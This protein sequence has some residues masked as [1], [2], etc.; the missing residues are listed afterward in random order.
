MEIFMGRDPKGQ[1]LNVDETFDNNNSNNSLGLGGWSSL[2]CVVLD[3]TKDATDLLRHDLD[4]DVNPWMQAALVLSALPNNVSGLIRRKAAPCASSTA[5]LDTCF[6]F[7][8]AKTEHAVTNAEKE[9]L[10]TTVASASMRLTRRT[11]ALR[12]TVAVPGG[13]GGPDGPRGQR[14]GIIALLLQ[15]VRLEV[16]E[17]MTHLQ[18]QREPSA[19]AHEVLAELTPHPLRR[20]R[21]GAEALR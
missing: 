9:I 7:D 12:R 4:A 21:P 15:R 10:K 8:G 2:N 20:F 19:A 18:L 14:A 13:L 3:I 11:E 6:N 5:F 17:P 1:H 16:V